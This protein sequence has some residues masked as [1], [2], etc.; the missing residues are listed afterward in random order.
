MN[1]HLT[2]LATVCASV[3]LATQLQAQTNTSAPAR[4]ADTATA[5]PGKT[6]SKGEKQALSIFNMLDANGDGRISREEAKVGFRLRPSLE[7]DFNAAD[8]NGDDYLT[9]QE[10][11]AAADRRRAER[12]ARRQREAQARES[13]AAA[14]SGTPSPPSTRASARSGAGTPAR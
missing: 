5:K 6:S 9:Q 1:K 14:K 2:F 4:T 13:A 11:R 8:T 7:A 12:K 3:L 10:I